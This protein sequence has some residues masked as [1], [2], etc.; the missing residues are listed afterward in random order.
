MDDPITQT[1]QFLEKEIKTYEALARFLTKKGIEEHVTAGSGS[2]LD[3]PVFYKERITE[4][5][6]L[7]SAIK[8][9]S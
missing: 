4:A 1:V 3:S 6:K 2:V 8:K 7:V 9:S 5:T